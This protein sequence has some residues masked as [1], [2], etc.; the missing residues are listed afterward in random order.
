MKM[1]LRSC[2]VITVAASGFAQATAPKL[3]FEVASVRPSA[4]LLNPA[5]VG[6]HID[7]QRVNLTQLSLNDYLGVAF[8]VK[9][10]QIQGPEW[11]ASQRFDINAKLPAGAKREQMNEMIQAL[12]TDRF[13]MKFHR[14]MKDFPVYALV[15]GKTGIK[16]KETPADPPD[17]EK[18]PFDMAVSASATSTTVN[19]GNGSYMSFGDNKFVGRKMPPLALSESLARF[20]DKPVVDMT[21]LR[22][23]YDF[24]LVF[25]PEDF[26][27]MM[28]RAALKAGVTLPPEAMKLLDGSNGD[29]LFN[30]VETLGLKLEERKAPVEVLV[31]DHMEKSPSDN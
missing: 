18:K 26:R 5:D 29:S 12:L 20:V 27:A 11:M 13:G 4:P 17:A 21:G 23:I 19:Y 1:I 2:L 30:A 16:M 8:K 15:V 6:V 28:I 22:G 9:L 25:S 14:E 10:H 3:E 24:D 7:G 31:I